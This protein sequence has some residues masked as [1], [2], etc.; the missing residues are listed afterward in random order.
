MTSEVV[1]ARIEPSDL[2]SWREETRVAGR[3]VDD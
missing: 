2:D 3:N 1:R